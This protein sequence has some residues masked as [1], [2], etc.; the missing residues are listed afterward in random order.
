MCLNIENA[1]FMQPHTLA[2]SIYVLFLQCSNINSI[3]CFILFLQG[4]YRVA[5][6]KV[7]VEK[8]CQTFE[9]GQDLV[10]ISEI[11]PH[12]ITSVLKLYLRQVRWVISTFIIGH[13]ILHCFHFEIRVDRATYTLFCYYCAFKSILRDRQKWFIGHAPI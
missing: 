3:F 12:L 1:L 2:K 11:Q 13:V 9:N 6:L 7:K 4:I 8:L 10:D 5:G